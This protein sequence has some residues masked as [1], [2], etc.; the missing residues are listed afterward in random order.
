MMKIKSV[1]HSI[2]KVPH[3]MSMKEVAKLMKEKDIGSV[4]VEQE[5]EVKG[6]L[7]ERDILKRVV[8]EG[9]DPEKTSAGDI[10]TTDLITADSDI[11]L[12]DASKLMD[13]HK[14]RRLPVVEHGKIIGIVTTRSLSR[15][16]PMYLLKK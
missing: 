14:I 3:D 1:M 8:A 4:L 11:N 6:I 2:T 16:L 12:F 5:N 13:K 15:G 10:M 9:K 7:T